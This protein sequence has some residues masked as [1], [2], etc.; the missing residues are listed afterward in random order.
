MFAAIGDAIASNQHLRLNLFEPVE[1]GQ[2]PHVGGANAPYTTHAD[3]GQKG[4]DGFR[5][6]RQISGHTIARLQTL[7][8]KVK[9][10]RGNSSSQFW[11]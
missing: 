8:L 11:P 3:G 6:V 10:H 2:G 5:N 7:G 4:N 9:G 1:Y